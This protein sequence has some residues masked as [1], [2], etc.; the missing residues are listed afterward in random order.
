[1]MSYCLPDMYEMAHPGMGGYMVPGGGE[2]CMYPGEGPGYCEP[3][4]L[5]HPPCMEQAWPASQHYCCSLAGGP[6]SFKNELC[7]R[8]VPLSHFHQQPEYFPDIKS[9]FSHLQ[10]IQGPHKR[11]MSADLRTC[12][13]F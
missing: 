3:Q 7:C 13:K 8:D 12:S 1:M 11:G 9:D 5:H 4:P 6:A 10:W 2:P